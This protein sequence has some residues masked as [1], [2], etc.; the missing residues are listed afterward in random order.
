MCILCGP[1]CK[2]AP[3]HSRVVVAN[4]LLQGGGE[5]DSINLKSRHNV[6][7]GAEAEKEE[8]RVGGV[9][10]AGEPQWRHLGRRGRE[11]SLTS[12]RPLY[13]HFA[14]MIFLSSSLERLSSWS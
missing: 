4:C 2:E 3:A 9:V 11:G 13:E 6:G 12:L 14:S 5:H 10:V 7:I 1:T 8:G